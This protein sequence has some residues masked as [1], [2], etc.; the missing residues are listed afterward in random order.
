MC[1][2]VWF[3]YTIMLVAAAEM[4]LYG[5]LSPCHFHF[6]YSNSLSV[7]FPLPLNINVIISSLFSPVT[8]LS[9]CFLYLSTVLSFVIQANCIPPK[10]LFINIYLTFWLR[11]NPAGG[12]TGGLPWQVRWLIRLTLK[13]FPPERHV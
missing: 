6:L 12:I 2:C 11:D 3:N 13:C 1:C 8:S 9:F 5:S 4:R 7:Y 10:A